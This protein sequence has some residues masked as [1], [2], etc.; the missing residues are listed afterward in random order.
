MDITEFGNSTR[1]SSNTTQNQQDRN[2][3]RNISIK[4]H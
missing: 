4:K 2:E 3:D 1:Q